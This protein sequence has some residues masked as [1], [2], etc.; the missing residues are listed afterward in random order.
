M[1]RVGFAC[2]WDA[3]PEQTWSGTPW[4]LREALARETDLVDIEAT[5]SR[6]ETVLAR[7]A[8]LRLHDGRVVSPWKQSRLG[9]RIIERHTQEAA[10]ASGADVVVQIGDLADLPIPFGIVQDL[11]I[12]LLM[13][14]SDGHGVHH[15]PGLSQRRL[16][17]LRRR[18]QSLLAAATWLFPMS[19]WLAG[20]L[21]EEGADPNKIT[22]VPPGANIALNERELRKVK[23][24]GERTRLL[25][26][27]RDFLRKGGRQLLGAFAFLRETDPRVSLTIIG[28]PEWPLPDAVPPGVDFRGA[29]TAAEVDAAMRSHDL[30]VMPSDFEG[31]GIVFVEALARGL[32]CIGRDACAMPEIITPGVNGDLVASAD[33]ADLYFV[34]DR[35]LSDDEVFRNAAFEAADVA[36]YYSWERAARQ[37]VAAVDL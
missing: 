27:G 14:G 34:I 35:T 20:S 24:R 28:P 31:Y 33:P 12:S 4:R 8:A 1:V 7:G 9:R 23:E 15:F 17:E 16:Q 30:F 25:F 22:V 5:P 6:P 10:A 3:R 29:R 26:V 11:S 18:Q 2:H 32:P 21:I 19:H 37:I 36:R 13:R